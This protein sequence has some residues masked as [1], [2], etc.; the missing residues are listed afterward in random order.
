VYGL[1]EIRLNKKTA[2]ESSEMESALLY[3]V[4][5]G[6]WREAICKPDLRVYLW[7]IDEWI[8]RKCRT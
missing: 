7:Y 6:N 4:E 5:L 3:V 2:T 1:R 8:E